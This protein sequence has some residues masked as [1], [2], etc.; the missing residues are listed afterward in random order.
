M[1]YYDR[2]RRSPGR[3]PTRTLTASQINQIEASLQELEQKAA[4]WEAKAR[5]WEA[6]ASECEAKAQELETLAAQ[7]Q[8]QAAQW[9]AEA[10][11]RTGG[12]AEWEAALQAAEQKAVEMHDRLARVQADYQ[13]SKRR[14]EQR[15]ASQADEQITQFM[16]DLLPVLD[17]LD[18]ALE[19]GSPTET[20]PEMMRQGVEM[21]RQGFLNVLARQGIQPLDVAAGQP[22]DPELHEAVGTVADPSYPPG[23]VATVEQKGYTYRDKLLRP[24]RT[25]ITPLS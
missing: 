20:D 8:E 23:T 24:A 3:E 9:Q 25:L 5:E 18:R 21:T 7:A 17:N 22:F 15:F 19:H 11:H 2:Y 10:E 6:A 4:L 12:A 13:N 14:L 1:S 16:R